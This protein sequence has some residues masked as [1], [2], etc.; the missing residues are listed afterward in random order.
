MRLSYAADQRYYVNAHVYK[1]NAADTCIH[2]VT[3]QFRILRYI[4]ERF[5]MSACRKIDFALLR[6]LKRE[7]QLLRGTK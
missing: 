1:K 3:L 2:S 5:F 4:R 6:K 7:I